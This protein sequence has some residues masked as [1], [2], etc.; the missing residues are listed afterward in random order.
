MQGSHD[1]FTSR[2]RAKWTFIYSTVGTI[3]QVIKVKSRKTNKQ[4]K[5]TASFYEKYVHRQVWLILSTLFNE[6]TFTIIL[7]IVP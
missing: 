5:F 6:N 3:Q 1:Q 7:H 4:K 2:L